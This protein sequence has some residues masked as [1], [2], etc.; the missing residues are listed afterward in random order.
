M[1]R[2]TV[3]CFVLIIL[4]R[5]VS[6]VLYMLIQIRKAISKSDQHILESYFPQG[7]VSCTILE[8]F[9]ALEKW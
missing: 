6:D 5:H 9:V 3:N 7:A 2:V 8:S 4:K 1:P